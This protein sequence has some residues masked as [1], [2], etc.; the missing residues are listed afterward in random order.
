MS[1]PSPKSYF[2]WVLTD[3][4]NPVLAGELRRLSNGD[5]SLQYH[6]AWRESGYALSPDL[7]LVGIDEFLPNHRRMR[8]KAAPGAIEDARPDNWGEKVIRYLHKPK[9]NHLIDY[10][11]FAGDDRF[12]ALGISSSGDTYMPYPSPALPRL[13]DAQEIS[14]TAR[15][16]AIDGQLSE[17]QKRL[18]AANASLGGAKPKAV[19]SI[20]G[21][22][23]V[24]KLFNGEAVDHP[25]VEH[26]TMTLAK[27]CG[28]SVAQTMV[29]RLES[30][31]AIAIKRFDRENGGKRIHCL[32]ASTIIRSEHPNGSI[33]AYGYPHLARSIRRMGDEATVKAQLLELFRRMVFN[34]LIANTD[35]HEKNH[36]FLVHQKGKV[37]IL[38]LSPAYDVVPTG[39]GAIEHEFLIGEESKEPL[40]GDAVAVC[41]Q[42]ELTPEAATHE[43]LMIISVVNGWKDHFI[44]CGVTV[45]DVSEL[46]SSIDRYDLLIQRQTFSNA[47]VSYAP[48]K[49]RLGP[50]A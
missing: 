46:E 15:I 44:R 2:L 10:L 43:I 48:K 29:V 18:A 38:R 24:L 32:S 8:E 20:G 4:V 21:E 39:S 34:I 49:R 40:L 27:Q 45:G 26:A 1:S 31:H 19:I 23:W 14:E 16:I 17:Q 33:P 42:F 25:L 6:Q 11:Y 12:G 47:R 37:S 28:I 7:P 9:G 3:P 5:V 41:A 36:A 13:D 50:F 35:D 22:E 30:E